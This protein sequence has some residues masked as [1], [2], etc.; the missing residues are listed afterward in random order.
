MSNERKGLE[1]VVQNPKVHPGWCDES[2]PGGER[3]DTCR[4][5]V[6]FKDETE[7]GECRRHPPVIAHAAMMA[8]VLDDHQESGNDR[9]RKEY[10]SE[11]GWFDPIMT[12]PSVA[13]YEWCGEW[14]PKPSAT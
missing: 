14:K 11:I 1:V 7:E 3:C 4:Y 2:G 9:F 8:R 10:R 12:W 5:F 13:Y 6:D